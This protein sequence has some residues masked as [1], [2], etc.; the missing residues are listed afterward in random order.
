MQPEAD[1][2]G[3]RTDI[4]RNRSAGDDRFMNRLAKAVDAMGTDAFSYLLDTAIQ[5]LVAF[6]NS[7]LFA[8]AP[9]QRPIGVYTDIAS[10]HEAGIIVG[11]YVLGP[12]LL[13]PFYEEVRR[14]RVSGMAHLAVIAPDA[15]TE[16]EYFERHYRRT[17]ICDEIGFFMGLPGDVTAVLSI[18]RR[19]GSHRFCAE[20]VTR[21]EKAAEL[22]CAVGRQNWTE[23]CSRF[24]LPATQ[25]FSASEARLG[26]IEQTLIS[27][28]RDTLS[29]RQA[30][31]VSYLLKGH[32]TESIA[33]NLEISA[34]T[35]KV[36]RR[37]AYANLGISSQA[38]LFSIFIEQL[39][40]MIAPGDE[41]S[42][43]V[44]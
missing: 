25:V 19:G 27:L 10:E 15:F 9:G 12:Y 7:M 21:L 32:S 18:T 30:E 42:G 11:K 23:L 36:H 39:S 4:E 40:Q 35:V 22:V 29:D 20:E 14:G 33:L 26:P 28:K 43:D 31:I 41:P 5:E 16:T 38:E 13:D 3:D 8:Y 6:D 1:I 17:R 44:G 24:D 37:N 2:L 34:E